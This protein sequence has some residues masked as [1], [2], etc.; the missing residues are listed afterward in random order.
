MKA[1]D[2]FYSTQRP[3]SQSG[4][5]LVMVLLIVAVVS[6]LA[7]NFAGAF[8]LSVARSENRWHGAQAKAYLLGAEDL[9]ISVLR[10]DRAEGEVDNLSETWAQE[11]EPFPVEGGW[12]SGRV[13]DAQGLFNLN[14]LVG[15]AGSAGNPGSAQRFTEEQRRFIRLLQTFE[16]LPLA[17]GDAVAI[18][19]AIIDWLD[20]DDRPTGF[21]GAESNYYS[22]LDSVYYA[23]NQNF[24]SINEL[25]L[26][27]YITPELY[28]LLEPWVVVL[29]EKVSININTAPL[30]FFQTINVSTSLEA[31]NVLDAQELLDSLGSEGFETLQ[32]F[33]SSPAMAG[34]IPQGTGPD[35][36]GLS[37]NSEYFLL[38]S[39]SLVAKQRR[40]LTSLVLRTKDKLQI[41][42]RI[43]G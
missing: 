20:S 26:V 9:A 15:N 38:Y 4:A 24:F 7:I 14:S 16:T 42:R 25:R 17:Q 3:S 6:T 32:D 41:I 30:K 31:L 11:T 39:E 1:H 12:L 8:Q 13:V 36:K 37:I 28:A 18:V 40:K 27:R 2:S 19:E 33:V 34:I 43:D 23:A 29:P 22:S 5:I 21:G 35:V 10:E